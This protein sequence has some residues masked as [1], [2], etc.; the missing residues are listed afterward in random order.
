MFSLVGRYRSVPGILPSDTANLKRLTKLFA[1]E[2]ISQ[3]ISQNLVPRIGIDED[4]QD[5]S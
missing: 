2:S 4:C 5:R 3:F 1:Q